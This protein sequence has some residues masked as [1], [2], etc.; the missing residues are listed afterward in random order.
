MKTIFDRRSIRKYTSRKVTDAQLQQL[1]K[2]A[3]AAP[4]AGNEQPWEFVVIRDRK[5]LSA[6]PKYHP[7][8][9]M[10]YEASAAILVCGDLLREKYPGYWVQD[11]SASTQNI[12][13]EAVD[14]GLGAVWLGIYPNDERVEETRKL[15]NIPRSAVPFALVSLGYPAEQKEPAER[16]EPSRIHYDAW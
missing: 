12:L 14:L 11:C 9:L 15:L 7:Y 1:L 4:S 5:L 13:L 2:A 3:M 6:V 16:F 10:L 8:S